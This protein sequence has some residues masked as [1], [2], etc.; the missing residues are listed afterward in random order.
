MTAE[1]FEKRII[2]WAGNRVGVEA[3]VL[4]G[5]RAK[6]VGTP[7]R[8]ADWDFH[9]LS[10]EPAQFYGTEWL[11]EIAPIWCAHAERTPRGVIKVSAVFEGGWEADFVPLATWQMKLVY[12]AMRHPEWKTWM[13]FRLQRGII[14]TRAFLLGSGYRLVWGG[15]IWKRRFDA[16]AVAWPEAVMSADDFKNHVAAF[17]QKGVWVCKKILRPEPRS[18]M[19]WMHK[20]ITDH[21]YALLAEE[22][23]L[24]GRVPRPEARKAEQWL[25]ETRLKQTA[26]DTSVESAT[27]ARALLD[28]M[29]LFEQ[30]ARGVAAVRGFTLVDHSAV[31]A[32]MRGELA[33]LTA[34]EKLRPSR[35]EK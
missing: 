34:A 8:L 3:L 16:L 11:S 25:S 31:A 27:L 10:S 2:G 23:R 12:W 21:V 30:V 18:A 14:E 1:E 20:L 4:A 33:K 5:S 22:A 19:H 9:L 13:P 35:P 26:I 6:L 17:W 32:W 29:D 24:A 28:E 15:D 7:D